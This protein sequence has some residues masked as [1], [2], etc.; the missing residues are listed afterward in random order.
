MPHPRT[1]TGA[2]HG[3]EAVTSTSR[4]AYEQVGRLWRHTA[5]ELETLLG[6]PLGERS[7][8]VVEQIPQR[9][10]YALQVE[11]SGFV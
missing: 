9:E 2:R 7:K 8:R 4:I 11:L 6:G 5:I 10:V 1:R 3:Y